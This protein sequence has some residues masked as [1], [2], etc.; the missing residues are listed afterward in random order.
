MEYR[1]KLT[2]YAV[3][4][5]QEIAGYISKVLQ[6]PDTA[7]TVDSKPQRGNGCTMYNARPLSPN[8]GG[9]MALRGCA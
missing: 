8:A 5:M 1:V 3:E 4:Q 2:D 7:K 6:A 9:A